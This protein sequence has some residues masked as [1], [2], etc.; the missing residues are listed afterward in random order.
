MA[1]EDIE[2]MLQVREGDAEAFRLLASRYREPL[3]RYFAAL[4]AEP[5]AADDGAQETLLRLWL[6]RERYEPTGRFANYLFRIAL[7]YLLN[8]RKKL[9]PRVGLEAVEGELAL[10]PARVSQPES[11]LLQQGREREIR[12]AIAALPPPYRVV[13]D[14]AHGEGLK[15]AEIAAQLGIPV[16]TVKSRMAGA[17]RRLREALEAED[18]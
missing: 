1:P 2:L 16:G 13:F 8:Q 7:H 6:T 10:A 5:G 15:Y 9:R 18:R 4:L 11:I 12:R 14:L 3:R 17:V